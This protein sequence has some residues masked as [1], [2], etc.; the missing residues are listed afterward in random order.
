MQVGLPAWHNVL[1]I[2]HCYSCD[3]GHNCG[4]DLI[5]GPGIPYVLGWPKRKKQKTNKRKKTTLN[6]R[7]ETMKLLE[8]NIGTKIL[9]MSFW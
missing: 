6:V 3:V 2:W 5:P 4:L 8:E 9:N 1:R 7:P